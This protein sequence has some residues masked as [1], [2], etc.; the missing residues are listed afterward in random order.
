MPLL[1]LACVGLVMSHIVLG[2]AHAD[3]LAAAPVQ[4]HAP[5]DDHHESV[6]GSCDALKAPVDG[7]P[8]PTA[9]SSLGQA[10]TYSLR[11]AALLS[12]DSTLDR[13]PRFLLHAS[14]LI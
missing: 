1:L 7:A 5:G 9:A 2:H 10:D 11:H 3:L 14:L 13:P 12:T 4:D 6:G 8:A